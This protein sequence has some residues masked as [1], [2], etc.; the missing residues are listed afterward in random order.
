MIKDLT[1]DDI[2]Q[3]KELLYKRYDSCHISK[4]TG[5]FIKYVDFDHDF[6]NI[7]SA[8]LISCDKK[9]NEDSKRAT[10]AKNIDKIKKSDK[11]IL[12]VNI[13]EE[14]ENFKYFEP[15][16]KEEIMRGFECITE[17]LEKFLSMI[18][19]DKEFLVIDI[20]KVPTS[21]LLIEYRK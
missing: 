13:E 20:D 3:I 10:F 2:K 14:L 4:E 1:F 7:G 8:S 9:I 19:E 6:E 12:F 16:S 18:G 5:F 17:Q 21:L 15:K 11:T